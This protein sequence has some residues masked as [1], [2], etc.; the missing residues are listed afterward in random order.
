MKNNPT[1]QRET[2]KRNLVKNV[3]KIKQMD[4]SMNDAF[5]D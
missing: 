2:Q 1:A 3:R 5:L 4:G